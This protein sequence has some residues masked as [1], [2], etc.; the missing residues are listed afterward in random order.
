MINCFLPAI[1]E[2]EKKKMWPH[3]HPYQQKGQVGSL[4]CHPHGLKQHTQLPYLHQGDV[5]KDKWGA[6]TFIP[7]KWV[8]VRLPSLTSTRLSETPSLTSTRL[9]VET[10]REPELPPPPG[11]TRLPSPPPHWV[12][13][14]GSCV[15]RKDYH[16][17]PGVTT[18]L[19]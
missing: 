16:C 5:T 12:V 14:V 7:I 15:E 6:G 13:S 4:D 19:C 9:S 8:V 11:G 17:G 3:P 1:S 18:S 2:T 10:I